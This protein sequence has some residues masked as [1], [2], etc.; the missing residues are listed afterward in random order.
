MWYYN[1]NQIKMMKIKRKQFYVDPYPEK[2]I[3]PNIWNVI[4]PFEH[5]IF[6]RRINL[7]IYQNLQKDC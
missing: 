4:W 3:L 5:Y 2:D 1:T 6:K 7:Y